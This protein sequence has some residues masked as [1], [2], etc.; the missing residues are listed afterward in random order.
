MIDQGFVQIGD[1]FG[2]YRLAKPGKVL[3]ERA[4]LI[5]YFAEELEA[6][7]KRLGIRLAHYTISD[8]YALRSAFNDRLNRNGKLA[9]RKYFY[10]I[11]KTAVIPTTAPA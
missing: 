6:A 5:G 11:T 9:A 7:P 3:D 8:L 1:L 4:G 2:N 10:W